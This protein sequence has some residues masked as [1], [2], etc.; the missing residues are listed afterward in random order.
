MLCAH[1][2]VACCCCTGE[3]V[4]GAVH[5]LAI[6]YLLTHAL[7]FDCC[8]LQVQLLVEQ[9][10]AGCCLISHYYLYGQLKIVKQV[11]TIICVAAAAC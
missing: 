7:N 6:Y 8:M 1:I 9:L 5:A 4:V 10:A 2:C 11:R 3:Y